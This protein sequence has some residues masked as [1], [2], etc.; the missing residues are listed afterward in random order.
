MPD[1]EV[2]DGAK[3]LSVG[4]AYFALAYLGL[5]L[6]SVN[7]SATPIWPPTGFAIATTLLWGY[8][9]TPA[10]FVAAFLVNQ[11]TAGSIVTSM[12][13]ALGN[14]LEATVAVYLV[15]GWANGDQVFE[16]PTGVVKFA[17]LCFGATAVSATIGV[18]SLLLGDYVEANDFVAVWLTWWLGDLAGALVVAPVVLLWAKSG[19]TSFARDQLAKTSITFLAAVAV[20]AIAFSPLIHQ[21]PARDPLGFLAILPL[22]WAALRRSPRDTATVAL[23]LASFAIWGTMV[24]GGPFARASLNDS[25]L[26]L[27]MFMISTAVPSLALSADVAE[28][29]RAQD[30]E[31]VLLREL[32]HRV[33]NTLAVLQSIFRRSVRHARSVQDLE[34]AFEGRLMNLAATHTLLS[35]T[36]W[37][38]ASLGDLI[39]GALQPYCAQD[40]Q[41]CRFSGAE[42][43]IPGSL[44]LS[45]TMVLHELATNAAKHGAFRE[46]GGELRVSWHEEIDA[47][48][49]RAAV[50]D[51]SEFGPPNDE[52][53]RR[54]ATERP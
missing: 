1:A 13:I 52:T 14:T 23:I 8:R 49:R 5:Q 40:F 26:L 50:I 4:I 51:W 15:K 30:Q 29:Q 19:P 34:A 47:A 54:R 39:R 20:G 38:S 7:P 44:V 17:L 6:A 33:G 36:T 45:V 2:R 3:I 24:R 48:G 41:D 11:L 9:I 25:F 12:A 35:E 31:H 21:T 53:D 27:L 42:T 16:T 10:I 37:Q 46:K 18:G 43:S 32:S 28:R 22:L